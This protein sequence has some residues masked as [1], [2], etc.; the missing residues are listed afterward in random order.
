MHKACSYKEQAI[1]DRRGG[2]ANVFRGEDRGRSVAIKVVHLY[3]VNDL[4]ARLGVCP[5]QLHW[6][7]YS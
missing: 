5:F 3:L 2:H 4:D 1:P 7:N 6:R